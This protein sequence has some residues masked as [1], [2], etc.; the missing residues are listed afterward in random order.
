MQ[1]KIREVMPKGI[2]L[3]KR[4]IREERQ[5]RDRAVRYTARERRV[6]VGQIKHLQGSI[7]KTAVD[8][9][10]QVF[11]IFVEGILF[12]NRLGVTD[13]LIVQSINE[14]RQGS[15]PLASLNIS[16]RRK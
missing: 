10:G 4:I 11:G 16:I 8:Q 13:K 7:D 12:E 5:S 14:G 6:L 1:K 15:T 9:T 2:V 3:P